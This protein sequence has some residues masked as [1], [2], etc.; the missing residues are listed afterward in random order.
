M[1]C[2]VVAAAAAASLPAVSS[3]LAAVQSAPVSDGNGDVSLKGHVYWDD[4]IQ[5]KCYGVLAVHE[6]WGR[7]DYVRKRAAMLAELDYVAFALDM[8]GHE[9]A[10]RGFTNPDASSFGI[11]NLEYDKATDESSWSSMQELFREVL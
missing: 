5:G 11:Q 7:N 2:R 10:R 8:Y 3:A 4:S 6:R 1:K 9:G